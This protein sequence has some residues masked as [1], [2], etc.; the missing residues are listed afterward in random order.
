MTDRASLWPR[1]RDHFRRLCDL[2]RAERGAALRELAAEDEALAAYVA[3][4]LDH[5]S[6]ADDDLCG[7]V[8]NLRSDFEE[9]SSAPPESDV[10]S[11]HLEARIGRGGMGE[12]WRARRDDAGFEQVAAL[13]LLKRGM[14]SELLLQRFLQERRILA[15]L[16]HPNIA[17]LLDGG[18]TGSGRPYFA[19]ELVE[20][21]PIIDYANAHQLDLRSM[22]RLFLRICGAVD[23]AHRNLVVHR[24]LKPSNI[25][26]DG[27]GEPKLLDFGIAKLLAGDPG[28]ATVTVTQMRAMTPAYAAPE[29]L[30]GEP[31]TTAT[32]VYSLGLILYEMVAGTLPAQRRHHSRHD[33]SAFTE[34]IT[35]RPSQ[36]LRRNAALSTEGHR[37]RRLA[38]D[39]EGDFDAVVL[40][41][42]RHDP[43]R[44]YPSVAALA[45]DIRCL[46][47][48]RPVTAR[49]DS[50]GYRV[51]RFLWRHRTGAATTAVVLAA[52]ITALGVSL[53]QTRVA[54]QALAR[55][56]S[57]FLRAEAA[58]E[59]LVGLFDFA[60]PGGARADATRT[61]RDLLLSSDTQIDTILA[62]FPAVQAE[63]RLAVAVALRGFGE[64]KAAMDL[65]E[66]ALAQLASDADA[67]ISV[68]GVALHAKAS[69]LAQNGELQA[70]EPFAKQAL[71]YLQRLPDT[72]GNARRVR[73]VNTTLALIY[74]STGREQQALYLRRVDLEERT[75]ELGETHPDLATSWFNLGVG[76]MQTDQYLDALD[77]F[78]RTEVILAPDD[79]RASLRYIYVWTALAGTYDVLGHPQEATRYFERAW[80]MTHEHFPA[81]QSTHA[82]VQRLAAQ[83]AL[84][85]GRIADAEAPARMAVALAMGPDQAAI[86]LPLIAWLLA[87]GEFEEA[88]E[89]ARRAA[90]ASAE[91]RG[92]THP[93]TLH[94]RAA[95]AFADWFG[96]GDLTS[97]QTLRDAAEA[98]RGASQR[99]YFG[100]AAAWL[101]VALRDRDPAAAITW[102]EEAEKALAAV[103]ADGHPWRTSLAGTDWIPVRQ[104]SILNRTDQP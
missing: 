12:V 51:R 95:T 94:M 70:A 61:V 100:Q 17:R 92:E 2:D 19:M 56:E 46:L 87:N 86:T 74:N 1:A 65:I 14:D 96:H 69:L 59:F 23:F 71:E 75:R 22:L 6:Q 84:S 31:V 104:H 34:D 79:E 55:M 5:D 81:N 33:G 90:D 72:P 4:L 97:L 9:I 39:A 20:G 7:A 98:M 58:K 35:S 3:E 50:M 44:R 62:D 15:R 52:L 26:V 21:Q 11:W 103:Y 40:T 73:A 67:P 8:D 53:W 83:L 54:N 18:M 88:G 32:D 43:A 77:A 89:V 64:Q 85:E 41:A 25:M 91:Q 24:D 68:L 80:R 66:T 60:N 82:L 99:R 27:E 49:A 29:Q 45:A 102:R 47:D 93:V 57:E 10:G 36:A 37:A 101:A 30:A 13:K 42:L 78:K 48:G 28:E 38:S 63:M 76:Y 16:E